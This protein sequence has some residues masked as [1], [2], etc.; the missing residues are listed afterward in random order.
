MKTQAQNFVQFCP[1]T[2]TIF[3]TNSLATNGGYGEL[4]KFFFPLCSINLSYINAQWRDTLHAIYYNTELFDDSYMLKCPSFQEDYESISTTLRFDI[5][6]NKYCLKSSFDFSNLDSF[7][8]QVYLKTA[9]SY[10]ETQSAIQQSYYSTTQLLKHISFDKRDNYLCEKNTPLDANG[11]P[12]HFICRIYSGL[13][14]QD[15]CE[16]DLHLFYSPELHQ[17][18]QVSYMI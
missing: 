1:N 15:N 8:L 16:K 18:A 7:W 10:R 5:I 6:Q 3:D 17:V 14:C 4:A 9:K 2:D 12:M 11:T 13:F